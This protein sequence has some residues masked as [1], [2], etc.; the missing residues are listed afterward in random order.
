MKPRHFSLGPFPATATIL[1][2]DPATLLRY[3]KRTFSLEM[4]VPADTDGLNLMLQAPDGAVHFV[5]WLRPNTMTT[6]VSN[7]AHETSHLVDNLFKHIEIPPGEESGETR[8]YLTGFVVMQG[9]LML[10]TKPKRK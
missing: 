7:L 2:G 4:D 8:A 1:M 6:L 9:L 5:I 3:L 10:D